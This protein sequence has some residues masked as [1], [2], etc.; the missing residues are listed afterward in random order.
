MWRIDDHFVNCCEYFQIDWSFRW[1]EIHMLRAVDRG[2][3]VLIGEKSK[4]V[5]GLFG[6]NEQKKKLISVPQPAKRARLLKI[7]TELKE[8]E[9]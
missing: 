4:K 6:S 2:V 9:P 7:M 8:N 1:N 5:L 3:E